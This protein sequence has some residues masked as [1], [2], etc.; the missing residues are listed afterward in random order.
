MDGDKLK[1]NDLQSGGCLKDNMERSAPG[2]EYE[3]S[4]NAAEDNIA[5]LVVGPDAAYPNR[6][7][8]LHNT[9]IAAAAPAPTAPT[10][11]LRGAA[12]I[13]SFIKDPANGCSSKGT[14]GNAYQACCIAFQL[15]GFPCGC[16]LKDGTGEVG[17]NCGDCGTTFGACC[18]A[19]GLRQES[20]KCDIA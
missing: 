5:V 6:T 17:A 20:C 13:P 4:Y 19:E 15:K 9:A 1:V 7:V 12:R 8:V 3:M 18:I 16:H 14:C 2:Y 11:A 10:K